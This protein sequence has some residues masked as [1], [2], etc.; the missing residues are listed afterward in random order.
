VRFAFWLV[1]AAAVAGCVQQR[2][3]RCKR[4]CARES[5]CVTQLGT[6]PFDEK[7]CISV[8]SRLEANQQ[9]APR[10]QAHAECVAAHPACS[11]ALECRW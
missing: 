5:E 3:E 11:E 8:C 7:Q 1:V 9:A 10:V 2:S 6:P 4:A